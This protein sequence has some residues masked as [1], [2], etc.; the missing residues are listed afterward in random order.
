M[1]EQINKIKV[2]KM[3]KKNSTSTSQIDAVVRLPV[4]LLSTRFEKNPIKK[5]LEEEWDS[6]LSVYEDLNT[7]GKRFA[8]K[9]IK[10]IETKLKAI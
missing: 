9:R 8:R 10:E 6:L 5:R 2:N 3:N 7:Y 4:H 1:C